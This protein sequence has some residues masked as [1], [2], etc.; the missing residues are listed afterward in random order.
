MWV[1]S[2]FLH[3]TSDILHPA[4]RIVCTILDGGGGLW[5]ENSVPLRARAMLFVWLTVCG[6]ISMLLEL[7][8]GNHGLLVPLLLLSAFYF[9]I[10][11]GWRRTVI[12]F[13][14]LGAVADLVLG[15]SLPALICL[16]PIVMMLALFWRRHGDCAMIPLQVLPGTAVGF[17]AVSGLLIMESLTVERLS[18]GLLRHS[19]WLLFHCTLAGAL[20]LPFLCSLYDRLA[21]GMAF[22]CYRNVRKREDEF[23][24]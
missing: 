2:C 21:A 4:S 20:L 5:V 1:E 12:P 7:L 13:A 8:C 23:G 22:P 16:L 18:A 15:R 9:T 10:T 24:E 11:V 19:L 14:V 17:V 6:F 3:L